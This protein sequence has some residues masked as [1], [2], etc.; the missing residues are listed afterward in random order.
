[1]VEPIRGKVAKVLNS[2]EIALNI[3]SSSGVRVGMDFDIM[4]RK[5]DD[6][7]DPD[8]MEILGSIERPKVR[9]RITKVQEKLSVASTFR[10]KTVNIGGQGIGLTGFTRALMPPELVTKYETLKTSEQTWEDLDESESYVRTGDPVVQVLERSQN[11]EV[12]SDS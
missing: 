12:K 8:T 11:E 5:G 3:G 1:M 9:V 4:D 6:I 7:R 10:E 2:K